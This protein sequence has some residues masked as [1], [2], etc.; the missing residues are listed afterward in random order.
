MDIQSSLGQTTV[1]SDNFSA[2]TNAAYATSGAINTTA[3]SVTRLG[4]DWGA[5]R[6]T[7]PAQL[8][9]TND[10]GATTNANGWAFASV[11]VSNFTSPYNSTL[12][13]NL[14][15]VTWNFNM[16]QIRATAS[17]FASGNYGAAMILG[18]TGTTAT[19]GNGYAVTIGV[20]GYIRL[21]RFTNGLA[22]TQTNII[23]G[24]TNA[25][26]NYYSFR[27][28]YTPSTNT[29]QLLARNDATSFADPATGALT[30][31][32]TAAVDNIYTGSTLANFGAFWNGSTGATQTAFFDNVSV[33]VAPSTDANLSAYTTTA[34]GFT[35][36]F[37]AATF[38][39]DA[40]VPFATTTA[41]V[42]ATR[43]Q[44]AATLQ[45][46]VNGGGYTS[47]ANATASG[48][49][50][51]N[52]GTNT[53][54]VRVTAED[55]T[56]QKTYTL[57]VT[58]AAAALLP[59]LAVSGTTAHGSACP[60][61]AA[62]TKTY[63]ITNT[64]TAASDVVVSSNNA[65]FV[66]SNL[67]STSIGATNGTATYDVTFT[68][69]STGS[70]TA[71]ITVYY[72]TNTSATTSSLSGT[73]TTPV[74]QAVTSSAASSIAATTA[75]L[76]GNLTA[77]GV[78]PSTSQ[79][80]FVYAA[81]ATNSDPLDGGTGV[82]KIS[83]ATISTGAYTLAL[84]G[85]TTGTGYSF[86]SYVYD[87]T[88]Y[89]Y[90]SALTFTTLTPPANDLC[91]AVISLTPGAAAT[92]GTLTSAT[93]STPFT[94]K[95]DVWFSFVPTCTGS[96]IITVNG[97][98]SPSEDIDIALFDQSNACPITTAA[99]A[100]SELGTATETITQSLTSGTTYYIRV[101]DYGT[102][103]TVF[104]IAVTPPTPVTQTV[105][106][107]AASSTTTTATLNGNVTAIGVCPSTTEKGFVYATTATNSD[108][109]V[110]GT[111]VTKTSVATVVNGAYTLAL[112]GLTTGTGYSFKSYVYDGTTYSYGAVTTFTT[113]LN[114]L[115]LTA[116]VSATVDAPFN[117]TF[118]D[119]ATWRAAI[120]SVTVGGTA[121]SPSAYST[122]TAGQITF[123][124]TNSVLL[125]SSGSKSIVVIATGYAN[126]TVTQSIGF[127]AATKLGVTT[128]PTAPASNGAVLAAQPVVAI[129]DQYGNTVT[130]DNSTIVSAAVSAGSWTLGGTA[131]ISAS[132]GTANFSGLTATSSA[133]VSGATINFSSTPLTGVSSGTFNI[134][135]PDYISLTGLGVAATENFNTLATSGPSS[136]LPQGW[137]LSESGSNSNSSYTAGTGSSS[138][139]DSYSFGDAGST[140][141][142]FGTLLSG[143][144]T[145][146][147]GAKIQNNTSQSI[148]SLLINYTGETWRIGAANRSDKLDFQYST[149]ATSFT[150]GTWTDFN[151][152][153]YSNTGT[154][155]ASGSLLQ[156]SAIS[157]TISS[158]SITSGS[159]FWIRWVDFNASNSD[160]GLAIDD[161]S[162]SGCGSLPA[163]SNLSAFG[164]STIAGNGALVTVTS[165]S[166]AD[167]NYTVN[168]NVSGTNTVA[169]TAASMTFTSGTGTFT[170]S[171]L[172][173]TGNANV[174]NITSIAFASVSGCTSTVSTSTT[175]FNTVSTAVAYSN[176]QFTSDRNIT[177]GT[178]ELPIYRFQV[179]VTNAD[180]VLSN[181]TFTTPADGV[182]SNYVNTDITNFKAFLTTSTVFNNSTQLGS[183]SPS[184]KV[185]SNLGETGIAF[186]GLNATLSYT[187]Q[188]YY[189]WL[190]ADV[191]SGANSGRNIIVNAPTINITG[192]VAGTNSAT[193]KQSIIGG[194]PVN[195]YLQNP[196][197][198]GSASNWNT[199]PAG[200]GTALSSL[201]AVDVN[202]IVDNETNAIIVGDIALGDN[203]KMSV[204][205]GTAAK[206][207][208]SNCAITGTFDVGTAGTLELNQSIGQLSVLTLG[209]LSAGS[210]VE[211][212]KTAAQTVKIKTYH[213]LTLGG[214]SEKSAA[215]NLVVNGSLNINSGSTLNMASYV[216]SGTMTTST[217]TLRTQ[218]T[219][220]AP[221]PAGLT[222]AGL[223]L[224]DGSAAQTLV[225][226]TYANITTNNAA[227]VTTSN[228]VTVSELLTLTSGIIETGSNRIILAA[229]GSVTRTSG[230]IYGNIRRYAPTGSV[231]AFLLPIGDAV[232]YS[233][234]TIDF[235]G[236]VSGTG[237]LDAVVAI[238]NVAPE[239]A[240]GISQTKYVNRKWTLT[241]S[242]ITGFTSYAPTFTF[243]SGDIQGAGDPT[244]FVIR[245]FA[246]TWNTTTLGNAL[247]TSTSATGQ[248]N[249]TDFVLGEKTELSLS[250][251]PSAVTIC[252]GSNITF[253]A[254]SSS[255]PTPTVQWQRDAGA[256]FVNITAN[257]DAGTTYGGFN[258]NTLP[259]QSG[260][261]KHQWFCY[262]QSRHCN[263][264]S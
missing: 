40:T 38:A 179:D 90:G 133:A 99:L 151:N 61:N 171:T 92:S 224:L 223:L 95:N 162:I 28:I 241:N 249:F 37:A 237:Y 208:I 129:Q 113:I 21:V 248:T 135:A 24:S 119:D 84:T 72:S 141:R 108:P 182:S 239:V 207:T 17:G 227:G 238:P 188:T 150:T 247:A 146:T 263:G 81:T 75:N 191:L 4:A 246:S 1:F 128:Q 161:I 231:T 139:G 198:G 199:D 114:A 63:T 25:G 50:S 215:G 104:S 183:T 51:L 163:T 132:S 228:D 48:A 143:S 175:A 39:Y 254:G 94:S 232:N 123:S 9:I 130:S 55:A 43:N 100:S 160:D 14:G 115:T 127:G 236:S 11:P 177:R 20:S 87:G 164:A 96:H 105:T 41:T 156:S 120:S 142:S 111:G 219:S 242:G 122:T 60:G 197:G 109:L 112:T 169:S 259:I 18:S 57:T 184:G 46:Q 220:G 49:L 59:S 66:V 145:S 189:I 121:L 10:V 147:I 212:T 157:S 258:S 103:A 53:I 86:K 91:S 185:Q 116:A 203:S 29:W 178:A 181:V 186:T 174:V 42:T 98:N 3:W 82:T 26:T 257:L 136:S 89:T 206:L 264:K 149:D 8:E 2:N 152:L 16:R 233:P 125:Q 250:T 187:T 12:S 217:G 202:L 126:A 79:K 27:V 107:Q 56:T 62:T 165:S 213:N 85:L 36:A 7:S 201:T 214:A 176:T 190:T 172:S 158:L 195:Y 194:T 88:N 200:T 67:S 211:Y 153:D 15:N 210:T 209:T 93:Y 245:N 73:G 229:T 74:T 31:V 144:L 234:V 97:F 30:V 110:G 33:T 6:N 78:C 225:G 47:L 58:R 64:G 155:T 235:A 260:L 44:A 221:I 193:G 131:V 65:Q 192:T 117:V 230:H 253:T 167:G 118:V 180:A 154:S 256:G 101:Y 148:T 140:D 134:A 68:P 252:H 251:Q 261:Y 32:N 170:T 80:G 243:V 83:V 102:T 138:T 240:S 166:L 69:S 196:T 216:L 23:A 262:F 76:N 70:Q 71:T 124:P 54:N 5:R 218:N 19:T 173:N 106:A 159:T 255:S 52:V 226:G 45:V 168:Y 137:F 244:A 205:Q 13:S 204:S 222:V 22:G 35:P 34:S 77:I